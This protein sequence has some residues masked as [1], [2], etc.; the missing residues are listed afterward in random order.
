MTMAAFRRQ[1]QEYMHRLKV[2]GL[3]ERSQRVGP[4][5]KM[6]LEEAIEGDARL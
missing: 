4:Q 5:F 1:M 6:M 2:A 3:P